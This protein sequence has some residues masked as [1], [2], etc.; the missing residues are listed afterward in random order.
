MFAEKNQFPPLLKREP[1]FFLAKKKMEVLQS[2]TMGAESVG[3]RRVTV[4]VPAL[5]EGKAVGEFL[6]RTLA[7]ADGAPE[8]RWEILIVDDGS[9]DNT[10]DIVREWRRRDS[11]V[12]LLS[13]TRNFGQEAAVTA[14]L[15][16]ARGEAAAVM[17]ADGQ[18][19]PEM[20]PMML[21]KLDE[22]CEMVCGRYRR[23]GEGW[24]KTRATAFYYWTLGRIAD[25]GSPPAHVNNFRL[26]TRRTLDAF[27]SMPER[28]RYARGMLSWIGAKTAV[29]EFDRPPRALGETKYG[30]WR[31][32]NLA[33]SGVT[34]FSTAPLRWAAYLG[35][36]TLLFALLCAGYVIW[37]FIARD[38]APGWASLLAS[39]LIFS[40]AQLVMLGIIGEYV[41]KILKEVKRR[42]LYIV[43]DFAANHPPPVS[44][45]VR[46]DSDS[47]V[48]G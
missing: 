41:G 10:A 25:D 16:H 3:G 15:R 28:E 12:C 8:W 18:D 35:M 4:V 37:S 47:D 9:D 46:A 23:G 48:A 33:L 42:P 31:M 36:I 27:L 19:P 14:G 22:G 7:A 11:R 1:P 34:S 29:I 26:M 6:R 40:G 38:V 45:S 13:F 24:F 5:N 2:P 20:L 32:C 39:V 44:D 30:L 43:R 17:D 21:Q